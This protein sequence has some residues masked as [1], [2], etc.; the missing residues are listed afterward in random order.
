MA[1]NVKKLR[2]HKIRID[3]L[4]YTVD[5]ATILHDLSVTLPADR[6]VGLI[7]PNGCGKSTL[8]KHLYRVLPVQQGAIYFDDVPISAISLG[9][10]AQ[11]I[12]VMGQFHA[13]QFDFT[14]WQ[15]AMMGRTPYKKHFDEDTEEDYRIAAEALR[16]VGMWE[17]AERSFLS[18]SGGEQQ[19]VMLARV[20]TQEPTYLILDEPTNHL[21]I[22]YQFE[23]LSLVKD[24]DIGVIAALHDLNLAAMFCDEVVVMEKGRV[25]TMGP[26]NAVLTENLIQRIYGVPSVVSR[27]PEGY[28][29]IRYERPSHG[30][31]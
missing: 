22:T 19:R 21:D 18:L 3:G 7:G 6:F 2:L 11:C 26:S 30:P 13:V 25:V 24:L 23:L 16:R 12:G 5:D 31:A 17:K 8:L 28:P 1:D 27:H 14:V 29:M 4:S 10:A 20:L 9:E 15:V